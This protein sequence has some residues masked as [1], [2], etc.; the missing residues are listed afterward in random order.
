MNNCQLLKGVWEYY[1]NRLLRPRFNLQSPK[2]LQYISFSVKRII[3]STV[4]VDHNTNPDKRS[5]VTQQIFFTP[6]MN[7]A[8]V[9][10]T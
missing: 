9:Q 10:V 2:T 4:S 3:I 8:A 5:N 1:S 7:E 6:V